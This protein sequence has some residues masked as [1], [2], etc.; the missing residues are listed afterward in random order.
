MAVAVGFEIDKKDLAFLTQMKALRA[1]KKAANKARTTSLRDMKS[2]AKKRVRARKQ[3]KARLVN[4]ALHPFR[5]KS[6]DLSS[7]AWGLRVSGAPV[8]ASDYPHSVNRK[9]VRVRVN[10]G[11]STLIESAFVASM[12]SGAKGIFVR[13]GAKRLPLIQPLGSRPVDALLHAGEADGIRQ[14]GQ[15]SFADGFLRLLKLEL[16]KQV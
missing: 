15:D 12:P 10:K 5:G 4:R 9:G 13:R 8:L 1:A 7:M 2:E 16:D 11:K 6:R 14:R 3:L